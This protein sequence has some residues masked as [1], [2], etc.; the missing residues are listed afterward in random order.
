MFLEF[1]GYNIETFL[2]RNY[3]V[4]CVFPQYYVIFTHCLTDTVFLHC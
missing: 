4:I 1:I 2:N 3:K